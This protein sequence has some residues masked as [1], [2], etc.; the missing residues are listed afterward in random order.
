VLRKFFILTVCLTAFHSVSAKEVLHLKNGDILTGSIYD[1]R[2]EEVLFSFQNSLFLIPVALIQSIRTRLSAGHPWKSVKEPLSEWLAIFRVP[3]S[4]QSPCSLTVSAPEAG[5]IAAPNPESEETHILFKNS[6]RIT[7]II[8]YTGEGFILVKTTFGIYRFPLD[9]PAAENN[10]EN[11]CNYTAGSVHAPT[12]PT[13]APASR[14][15]CLIAGARSIHGPLQGQ[16]MI[17]A[18]YKFLH[19]F[20]GGR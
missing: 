11:L 12:S 8:L 17:V 6:D 14:R 5:T 7:G 9:P 18:I 10:P 20:T 13:L 15:P 19:S 4:V 1:Y 3:L 16:E 2:N